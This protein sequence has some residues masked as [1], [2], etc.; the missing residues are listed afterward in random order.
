MMSPGRE[1]GDDEPYEPDDADS[2]PSQAS[3]SVPALAMELQ[4][5]RLAMKGEERPD[6]AEGVQDE[7]GEEEGN[8]MALDPAGKTSCGI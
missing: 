5:T 7:R 4:I 2:P 6:V 3:P 1:E 8:E